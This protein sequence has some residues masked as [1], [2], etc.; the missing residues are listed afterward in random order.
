VLFGATAFTDPLLVAWC[1]AACCAA[2][3]RRWGWAGFLLGLSFASKQQ[4]LVLAPLVVGLGLARWPEGA[5]KR[6]WTAASAR[7]VL[8]LV[9]VLVAVF[10]WDGLRVADGAAAGFWGQ[11]VDS[12]GGLRLIWSPELAPRLRGWGRLGGYLLGWSWL[13]TLFLVAVL[14]LL[15]R[16][17]TRQGRTR[18]AGADLVLSTFALFYLFFHWLVAFPVWDRYLLPLVPVVGLLLGRVATRALAWTH[19][20]S[21]KW[22][23]ASC[24][25][26]FAAGVSRLSLCALLVLILFASGLTAA[27]GRIPVGGDH[28]AYDGLTEVVAFLRALPVGTVLYDR[29]LTWHYDFY[30]F[31]AYLFRAGFPS[32]EWLAADAAAFYDGHPRYLVIPGWESAA[33]LRRA[34]AGVSLALSPVLTTHRRD[35]T[36]SFVVYEIGAQS[37]N[38][39]TERQTGPQGH[40]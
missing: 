19:E 18:A 32:P 25:L 27:S 20:E 24:A 10:A 4:A 6:E 22:R 11:G 14:L 33:R 1:L 9:C 26:R 38:R 2:L 23:A 8:G 40:H 35:G 29:W 7:F 34:L 31:D 37:G 12:Y 39:D 15:W 5:A 30:L 16:D 13:G 28:G 36:A 3:S 17:V 21:G